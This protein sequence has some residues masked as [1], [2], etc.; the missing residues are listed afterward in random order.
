MSSTPNLLIGRVEANLG[1]PE[2]PIN[3]AFEIL[4]AA[5]GGQLNITATGGTTTLTGT[6]IAP[7]AQNM[8]LNVTGTLT[9]NAAIEIPVSA[10]TGRNRIYVVKNGTSGA[11]T[12]TVKAVGGTGVAVGQGNIVALLYNGAD[13][14]YLTPQVVSSTGASATNPRAHVYHNAN[15]SIPDSTY[16]ALALNQERTDID[17]VS[18]TQHDNSTNNSRLTC[19]V[20]GDYNASANLLYASNS[21]GFRLAYI[22][23]NGTTDVAIVMA[24]AVVGASTALIV[25]TPGPITLAV[26]DYLQV[27]VWQ[28]SGGAL[29]VDAGGEFSPEFGWSKVA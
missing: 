28:N 9:A 21:T 16:T 3:T 14:Q 6:P 17:G 1:S 2:I 26:G 15:Q 29:N 22:R 23:K 20:A 10:T 11:F 25:T 4:D 7:Q 24:N 5:I 27:I 8:F 19:R 12:L 18:N 13:I